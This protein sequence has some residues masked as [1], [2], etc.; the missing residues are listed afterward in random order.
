MVAGVC[1]CVYAT[2]KE[3]TKRRE[4]EGTGGRRTKVSVTKEVVLELKG[5]F[6]LIILY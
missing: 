5:P 3:G 1:V 4:Y 2:E 6:L